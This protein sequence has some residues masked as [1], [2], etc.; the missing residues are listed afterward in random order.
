MEK[1]EFVVVTLDPEHITFVVHV[2]SF[3]STPLNVHLSRRPQISSIIVKETSSKVTNE[4]I[5]FANV[6]S[7]NLASKFPKHTRI[8][9]QA[10]KLVEDH[11]TSYGPIYSFGPMQ[12]KTLKVYIETNLANMFIRPCKLPA[13]IFILFDRKPYESLQLCINYKGLNNFTTKNRYPLPMIGESLDKL[14]KIK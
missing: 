13:S 12:L 8:N 7:L 4:Y 3:S 10:I 9:N 14:E 1:K 6:F 2:A 5:D 11:Q